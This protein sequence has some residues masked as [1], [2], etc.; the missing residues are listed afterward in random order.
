MPKIV[1]V[2]QMCA[3][4]AA[5]DSQGITYVRMMELA[6]AAVF[7]AVRARAEALSSARVVILAGPG[8]N[9]GDGLVAGR[10]LSEAGAIVQLFTLRPL[11]SGDD[12]LRKA[13]RPASSYKTARLMRG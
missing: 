7:E 4:E 3:L 11:E 13:L 12:N 2:E 6:G 8:N 1:T 5:A 10:L 9:G